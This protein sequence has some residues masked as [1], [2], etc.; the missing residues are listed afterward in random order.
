[1]NTASAAFTAPERL[2][3]NFSRQAHALAAT[4]SFSP[5]SQI[6]TLPRVSAAIFLASAVSQ[7]VHPMIFLTSR[8]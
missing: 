8:R 7:S 5:G 1:M 6:A 4:S 3:V 2:L